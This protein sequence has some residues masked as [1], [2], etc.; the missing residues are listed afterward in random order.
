MKCNEAN[1]KRKASSNS[2]L[3]RKGM[4]AIIDA[5]IFITIIGLIAAGMFAYSS[6]GSESE[7]DA[8]R[9][10]DTFFAIE[11]KMNDVFDD[12]DTRTVRISDLIAAHLV[13]GDGNVEEYAEDV[14]RSVIPPIYRFLMTFEYDGHTL[15]IGERGGTLSSHYSADIIIA[16]GKVMRASL[17]LY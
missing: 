17:S 7:T 12:G 16:G 11:L 10:H 4:A 1:E 14:L 3:G 15:T 13:T 9:V 6:A 5:F 8:K 2:D